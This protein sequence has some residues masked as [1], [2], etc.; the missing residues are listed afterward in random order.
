LGTTIIQINHLTYEMTNLWAISIARNASVIL[1]CFKVN[2]FAFS[3]AILMAINSVPFVAVVLVYY[4][5]NGSIM[6]N[7]IYLKMH[8]R[9]GK[10]R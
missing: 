1:N 9:L 2:F 4:S 10:K 6:S 8:V 5:T 3:S 7:Q